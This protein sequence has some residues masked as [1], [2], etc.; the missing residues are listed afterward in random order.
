M[1]EQ[2][3]IFRNRLQAI[4]ERTDNNDEDKPCLVHAL[5]LLNNTKARIMDQSSMIDDHFDKT[6][7]H[8]QF[9]RFFFFEIEVN[10]HS[11]SS[12]LHK[13]PTK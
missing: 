12:K 3:D 8:H 4:I 6:V 7:R 2:N 9:F 11:H 1:D 13:T 10:F 5:S